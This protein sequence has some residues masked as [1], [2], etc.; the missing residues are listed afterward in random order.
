MKY[1]WYIT[2]LVPKAEKTKTSFLLVYIL[3]L[4]TGVAIRILTWRGE[5]KKGHKENVNKRVFLSLPIEAAKQP[6]KSPW[7]LGAL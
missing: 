7:G 2:N 6:I 1:V 4:L 5:R 3:L